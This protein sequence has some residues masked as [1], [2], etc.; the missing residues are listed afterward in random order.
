MLALAITSRTLM[1]SLAVLSHH[2]S[3]MFLLAA[4]LLFSAASFCEKLGQAASTP[5]INPL[6]SIENIDES[7]YEV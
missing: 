4:I 1:T 2:P 6:S 3:I 5:S 7:S